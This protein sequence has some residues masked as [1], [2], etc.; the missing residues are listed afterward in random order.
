V[1]WKEL[2]HMTMLVSDLIL[3][4]RNLLYLPVFSFSFFFFLPFLCYFLG[5]SDYINAKAL[6]SAL[7]TGERVPHLQC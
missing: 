1:P 2:A 3:L 4:L 7:E 6:K 5:S